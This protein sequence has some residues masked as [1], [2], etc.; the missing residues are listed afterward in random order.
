MP[1]PLDRLLAGADSGAHE[2]ASARTH[3][4]SR[5]AALVRTTLSLSDDAAVTVQQLT[6]REPGCPPVETVIAVLASNTRRWTLH[7]PLADVT[8]E[9]VIG[10]L[11][12]RPN[13][14]DND[15]H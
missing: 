7:S 1:G 10:L 2:L 5:V 8:D 4:A 6:C 11:T 15:E 12:D 14:D 9:L 3:Q 13:G